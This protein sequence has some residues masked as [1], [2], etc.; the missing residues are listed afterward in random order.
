MSP[1]RLAGSARRSLLLVAAWLL[2]VAGC[3]STEP[4]LAHPESQSQEAEQQ[5]A[6]EQARAAGIMELLSA[7]ASFAGGAEPLTPDGECSTTTAKWSFSQFLDERFLGQA[8]RDA[9]DP[10]RALEDA[11]AEAVGISRVHAL[12][13]CLPEF[14][15]LGFH[16]SFAKDG[17]VSVWV[18]GSL[19]E[20]KRHPPR[21]LTEEQRTCANEALSGSWFRA[22]TF[23]GA[24][25]GLV[26]FETSRYA[27]GRGS[28]FGGESREELP[29]RDHSERV[30]YQV[31]AVHGA[32]TA[33]FIA[34]R[35]LGRVNELGACYFEHEDGSL[36]DRDESK[37]VDVRF[38]VNEYGGAGMPK[39]V[40]LDEADT[41]RCIA[42]TI[43]RIDFPS[44]D[45][46]S[47]IRLRL[48]FEGE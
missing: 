2:A 18:A 16:A 44:S 20:S 5:A 35:L 12:E 25:I 6:V 33:D 24:A 45:P 36:R 46:R 9:D 47:T 31:T 40:G 43:V 1:D 13:A 4:R 11:F 30:D 41:A 28:L 14:P 7:D 32:L 10:R 15:K 22:D 29:P 26:S 27:C 17:K 38:E 23:E 37:V 48:T 42:I 39:V 3:G 8:M 21:R 19:E 34:R